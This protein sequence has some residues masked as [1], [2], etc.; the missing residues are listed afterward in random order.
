MLPQLL[1]YAEAKCLIYV[2]IL[3]LGKVK[4]NKMSGAI[5]RPPQM[6]RLNLES[7]VQWIRDL[8]DRTV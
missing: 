2:L 7:C 1:K 6:S 4:L 5:R 8:Q 3:P